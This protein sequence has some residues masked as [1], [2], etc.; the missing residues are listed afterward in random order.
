MLLVELLVEPVRL[1]ASLTVRY[2]LR[3]PSAQ[4]DEISQDDIHETDVPTEQPSPQEGPRFPDSDADE[5]RPPRPQ[6]ATSEGPHAPGG[7]ERTGMVRSAPPRPTA[8]GRHDG[9]RGSN[10][11]AIST[12]SAAAGIPGRVRR[13]RATPRALHDRARPTERTRCRATRCCRIETNRR[14]GCA[15]SGEASDS[16]D[17]SRSPGSAGSR[18]RRRAS[19]R[20]N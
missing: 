13:G 10:T 19:P 5:G 8:A 7:L 4:T 16:R 1:T 15:Q 11:A 14:G 12:N 2:H 6:A 18:R 9:T 20:A 3:L 17:L